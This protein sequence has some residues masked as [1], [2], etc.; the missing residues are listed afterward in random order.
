MSISPSR[1]LIISG[2]LG[3]VLGL[4]TLL[5]LGSS[6]PDGVWNYPMPGTVFVGVSV[7]LVV[8]HLLSAHGF[9]GLSRLS[10]GS[11]FVRGATL[12]SMAGLL[13]LS[14]AEVVS[15]TLVGVQTTTEAA[16]AVGALFGVSSLLYAVPALVG[17]V[18]LAKK[19]LL[20]QA[21][22]SLAASGAIILFL[23]T[24]ANITGSVVLR[25]ASLI[26]W[27]LVFVWMGRGLAKAQHDRPHTDSPVPSGEAATP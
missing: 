23:V 18:A 1:S 9:W 3:T 14:A 5:F 21:N 15:G 26:L 20:P 10:G 13:L 25:M 22:W 4:T 11:R 17:G 16:T 2:W 12:V 6:V 7:L 8:D 24:P 27:S 19:G